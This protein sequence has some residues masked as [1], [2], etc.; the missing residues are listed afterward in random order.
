MDLSKVNTCDLVKELK[1]RE[2]VSAITA[3]PYKETKISIDGPSV[4][5]IIID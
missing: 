2:G 4:I 1:S 5:L 3:E